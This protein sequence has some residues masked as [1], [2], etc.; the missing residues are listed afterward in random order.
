MPPLFKYAVKKNAP[1][2]EEPLGSEAAA[3]IEVAEAHRRHEY[4]EI[5][6]KANHVAHLGVPLTD[7][8]KDQALKLDMMGR[9]LA[10]WATCAGHYNKPGV[11]IWG[12]PRAGPGLTLL[13]SSPSGR[14]RLH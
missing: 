9:G 6:T 13:S 2:L 10:A 4:S 7:A 5:S 14:E 8:R 11:G 1:R 12:L 3:T